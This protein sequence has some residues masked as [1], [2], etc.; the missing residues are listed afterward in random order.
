MAASKLLNCFS[1]LCA[2]AEGAAPERAG[3][4]LLAASTVL[5]GLAGG[6]GGCGLF[7]R[8][9][10]LCEAGIFF[11]SGMLRDLSPGTRND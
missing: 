11:L 5:T 2:C 8:L 9:L 4:V 1:A 10:V 7:I 3:P 6:L